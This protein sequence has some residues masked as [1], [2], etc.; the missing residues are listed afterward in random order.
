MRGI[1]RIK[2]SSENL[3]SDLELFSDSILLEAENVALVSLLECGNNH[4]IDC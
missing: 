3:F 2:I 1:V 4:F